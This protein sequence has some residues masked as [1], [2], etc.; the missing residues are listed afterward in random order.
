MF[1]ADNKLSGRSRA[2]AVLLPCVLLTVGVLVSGCVRVH[3]AFAVTT[4]DKVSGEV[5]VAANDGQS[6]QLSVPS[7]L[8]G[9]ITSK[10]YSADGYTGT[11]LTFTDLTFAEVSTLASVIST[12]S[13]NY[14]LGFT[15]SGDLVTMTGSADLTDVPSSGLDVQVKVSFPGT[16]L[17]TQDNGSTSSSDGDTTVTW[18]LPAGR[19]TAFGATARYTP[20][21][22]HTMA[23]WLWS[24]GG[25]GLLIAV[26]LAFLALLAR[27]LHIRKEAREAAALG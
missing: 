14:Q 17:S 26:F 15:R 13:N 21:A 11:D 24:L 19:A 3:A 7:S 8:S 22:V 5:V 6:P 23:F 4:D 2:R 27:R 10:P 16:V 20:G 9:Q 18:T 1:R 25:A 12:S